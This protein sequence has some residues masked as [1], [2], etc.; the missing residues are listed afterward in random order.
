[1]RKLRNRL[2]LSGGALG[3]GAIAAALWSAQSAGATVI[4]VHPIILH[5]LP[6]TTITL[7]IPPL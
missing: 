3:G 1:M 4:V 6:Y 2:I 7:T 5:V